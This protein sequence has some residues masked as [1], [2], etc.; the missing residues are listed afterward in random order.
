MENEQIWPN[1][2]SEKMF[3][4]DRNLGFV[5]ELLLSLKLTTV[6][7]IY[8]DEIDHKRVSD[9]DIQ[10]SVAISSKLG[11][12]VGL[13]GFP[14]FIDPSRMLSI[15]CHLNPDPDDCP[16]RDALMMYGKEDVRLV[17][18]RYES[19]LTNAGCDLVNALSQW[20]DFKF[21]VAGTPR[22]TLLHPLLMSFRVVRSSK[23][24]HVYG[25]PA[26]REQCYD[27]IRITKN[28]WDSSLSAVNPKFIAIITEAAG[29]GSFLVLP[30]RQTGRVDP[31][32]PLVCGHRAAVLD[33]AWNPF[34]DNVIASC[35]EDTTIKIWQ[36]SEIGIVRAMTEPIVE[37]HGHQK[38]VG[39]IL[40]HPTA[41]NVILS[42][43][44][45]IRVNDVRSGEVLHEGAGHEGPKPQRVIFLKNGLIFT[46]GFSRRSERQY[47]LRNVEYLNDP[48]TL[49]DL[50]VSNGV[51]IP[52]V[53]LDLSL[54][55]LAAKGDSTIRYFEISDQA[56]Y[57]HYLSTFLSNEP[58]R[59]ITMMPKRGVDT[60]MN[61]VDR[62]YK[63]HAKG[64]IEVISMVVPRKSEMF[65]NDLYPDAPGDEPALTAEE[66]ME[67]QD[68]DP[69]LI[70][71]SEGYAPVKKEKIKSVQ[72]KPNALAESA[73]KKKQKEEPSE[74]ND[75]QS[76]ASQASQGLT[77][78][79]VIGEMKKMEEGLLL[80][81]KK[82][83]SA[84]IRHERKINRLEDILEVKKQVPP[85]AAPSGEPNAE[86]KSTNDEPKQNDVESSDSPNN[87]LDE[88]EETKNESV[89]PTE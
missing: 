39:C 65:Q 8:H 10:N 52:Y 15:H 22:Y 56:P 27:N 24:R 81:I 14:E 67:G 25:Q 57:V 48:I 9:E 62:I 41:N 72:K 50:D 21:H 6:E 64:Y 5:N 87:K 76:Q 34:N 85:E 82:L 54:V 74:E 4:T 32:H 33:I 11:Q 66:W 60:T 58:Q 78:A 70:S 71:L 3:N 31:Q 28:S 16:A 42:V 84:L 88:S 59:G 17:F 40:W 47:A 26:K 19:I 7:N 23:F 29:G 55:Y 77:A 51:L 13:S 83:K 89:V 61:E 37:L 68:S 18:Q 69:L 12:T 73:N 2:D 49:E 35:S 30:I 53:D 44:K 20:S 36:F 43:D 75:E 63:L 79:A 45:K 1:S 86:S 38:R 46:T 80:E